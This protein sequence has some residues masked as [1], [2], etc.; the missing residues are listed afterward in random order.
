MGQWKRRWAE[1]I[2]QNCGVTK[3]LKPTSNSR[4]QATFTETKKFADALKH[5]DKKCTAHLKAVKDFNKHTHGFLGLSV[6]RMFKAG[7]STGEAMPVESES[8]VGE[9]VDFDKIELTGTEGEE[10][11]FKYVQEPLRKW[12]ANFDTVVIALQQVE[13]L[14]LTLDSRRRS[15]SAMEG[16]IT[17]IKSRTTDPE[18]SRLMKLVERKHRQEMKMAQVQD[19]F[20]RK[21]ATTYQNMRHLVNDVK[22]VQQHIQKL[23]ELLRQVSSDVHDAFPSP[24]GHA[25]GHTAFS[26]DSGFTY[27]ATS[28]QQYSD[29]DARTAPIDTRFDEHQANQM[30]GPVR[31]GVAGRLNAGVD[32]YGAS[33]PIAQSGYNVV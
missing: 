9:G 10:K 27:G 22:Y 23:F 26:G 32:R 25:D 2:R 14:R 30:D 31:G 28:D 18:D 21:E 20:Q 17:N 7:S 19:D 1:N 15:V 12:L 11:I 33:A 8:M 24:E 4:L 16:E 13:Q 3:G 29:H 6:P 5:Y